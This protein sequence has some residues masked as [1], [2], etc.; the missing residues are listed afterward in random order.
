M[1]QVDI[2]RLVPVFLL[3]DK[4]GLAL[5]KA[6]EKGMQLFCKTVQSGID[7]A[8]HVDKMPEWRLDELSWELGCLYDFDAHVDSKRVWIRDAI[9]LYTSY[10]TVEAIYKYLSGYFEDVEVEESW[11]YRGE[12]FHFR[13]TVCGEL[14]DA[15]EQWAKRAINNTKNVRSVLDDLSIGRSTVIRTVGETG[16]WRFPY[17]MAGLE[18]LCGTLP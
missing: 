13:V 4:N 5:A 8:I 17:E 12:P 1:I 15:K 16:W 3:N 14:T 11:Q 9:P 2:S 10:G 7:T 6:L 18:P